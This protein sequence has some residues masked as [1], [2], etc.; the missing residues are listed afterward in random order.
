MYFYHYL[1][2]VCGCV[3]D[4]MCILFCYL[5]RPRLVPSIFFLFF[6]Y[7]PVVFNSDRSEPEIRIVRQFAVQRILSKRL[8]CYVFIFSSLDLCSSAFLKPLFNFMWIPI[9]RPLASSNDERILIINLQRPYMC[10]YMCVLAITVVVA[11]FGNFSEFT[12]SLDCTKIHKN[13]E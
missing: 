10:V 4:R 11:N 1:W 12:Q 6:T 2:S 8:H 13:D 5:M 3:R 9:R 7:C